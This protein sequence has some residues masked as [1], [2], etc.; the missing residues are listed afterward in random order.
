MAATA[1]PATRRRFPW[2]LLAAVGLLLI[3][4]PPLNGHAVGRHGRTAKSAYCWLLSCDPEDPDDAARY[5]RGEQDDGRTV[6]IY[7]LPKLSGKPTTWAIVVVGSGYLATAFLTQSRRQV[8]K[9][10]AECER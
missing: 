3:A 4:L 8:R 5:W 9:K 1:I 6:H 7:R 2:L 10:Q